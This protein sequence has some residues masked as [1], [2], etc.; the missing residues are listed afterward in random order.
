MENIYI[1]ARNVSLMQKRFLNYLFFSFVAVLLLVSVVSAVW[2]NPNTWFE[3]RGITGNVVSPSQIFVKVAYLGKI[4]NK[5][6]PYSFSPGAGNDFSFSLQ[7][8]SPSG[9][10]IQRMSFTRTSSG[11]Y[12]RTYGSNDP[13]NV[14]PI[15]IFD[16]N[17][18]RINNAMVEPALIVP[19]GLQNYTFYFEPG[20]PNFVGGTLTIHL[21][22]EVTPITI[23]VPAGV[24]QIITYGSYDSHVCTSFTY[25][26]WTPAICSL[27][28]QQTRTVTSR[29]PAGCTTGVSPVLTQGCNV[30]TCT[31][32]T[33]SDWGVCQSNNQQARTVTA[34][35]PAGC[36]GGS[37]L[38]YRGCTPFVLPANDNFV[39]AI[40]INNYA[41]STGTVNVNLNGAGT[42]SGENNLA[43]NTVWY[44]FNAPGAGNLNINYNSPTAGG[45]T[46][47]SN[48]RLYSGSS[49]SS[50]ILL[51]ENS[52]VNHGQTVSL[53]VAQPGNYY[54][55]FGRSAGNF[56]AGTATFTYAFQSLASG[57]CIDTDVNATYPD[58]LNYYLTGSASGS[59]G[60]GSSDY[61]GAG[62]YSNTVYESYCRA[63]DN[64]VTTAYYNCPTGTVCTNGACSVG[65]AVVSPTPVACTSFNVGSYN[66]CSGGQQTRSVTGVP[67]GCVGGVT[68]PASSQACSE[69]SIPTCTDAD[70]TYVV[71]AP[72][73]CSAGYSK[74]RRWSKTGN[75]EGGITHDTSE[76]LPC[77]YPYGPLPCSSYTYGEWTPANCAVGSQQTRTALGSYGGGLGGVY[78]AQCIGGNPAAISR[79]CPENTQTVTDT[80]CS[81]GDSPVCSNDEITYSNSCNAVAAG[82]TV[83]CQG[84]CP[85]PAG[86]PAPSPGV[87]PV[88]VPVPTVITPPTGTGI[89]PV[90]SPTGTCSSGCELDNNCVDFGHRS[91]AKYCAL[92]GMV[93]FKDIGVSCDNSFECS[94]NSCISGKCSEANIIQNIVKWFKDNCPSFICS[95][96]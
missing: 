21:Q 33:Y 62:Y 27:G 31:S 94:T 74:E 86:N 49:L 71:V 37:P 58:G 80:S 1:S 14:Y 29:S 68:P 72:S 2:W 11:E 59:S 67:A 7:F 91:S 25:S 9:L 44:R 89:A 76:Y 69:P 81:Y 66:A 18:H 85:C 43:G 51:R 16:S 20:S 46:L 8:D 38:L 19:S 92:S 26:A 41:S 88:A 3:G 55:Q 12:W 28:S 45:M 75:C 61:C 87:V 82:A 78:Y 39:N 57:A 64:S 30:P 24:G 34:S 70:W 56:G 36:T 79:I 5:A 13:I 48:L 53:N 4:D 93:D 6:A 32:F 23:N 60:I 10:K 40:L 42:E 77:S 63:S 96:K 73:T 52:M 15:V 22:N 54:L 47:D 17:N 83:S 95:V 35:S 90:V 65:S 50:L 84:E